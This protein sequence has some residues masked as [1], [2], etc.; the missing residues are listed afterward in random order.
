MTAVFALLA[1]AAGA[2]GPAIGVHSLSV[3]AA[4]THVLGSADGPAHGVSVDPGV[5]VRFDLA[6]DAPLSLQS[7]GL[8]LHADGSTQ[9][10]VPTINLLQAAPGTLEVWIAESATVT[11]PTLFAGANYTHVPPSPPPAPW[12]LLSDQPSHVGNLAFAAPDT[13][14]LATFSPPLSLMAGSYAVVLVAVPADVASIP[15]GAGTPADPT[16]LRIHPRYLDLATATAPTQFADAMLAVTNIGLQDRAFAAAQ[17]PAALP[18]FRLDYEPGTNVAFTESYGTGCYYRPQAFC[19]AFAAG[20][21]TD[22]SPS[23]APGILRLQPMGDRY[24]ATLHGNAAATL[25][26]APGTTTHFDALGPGTPTHVNSAAPAMALWGDWDDAASRAYPLPFGFPFPGDGGR[27]CTEIVIGSNGALWLSGELPATVR[28]LGEHDRWNE[29]PA[30]FAVAYCDLHPQNHISP[31]G[32]QGDLYID[33]DGQSRVTVSWVGLAEYPSPMGSGTD[34]SFQISLFADG[35]VEIAYANLD[36][37]TSDLL[38]G[39]TP[40]GAIAGPSLPASS[41]VDLEQALGRGAFHSGDGK[42]SAHVQ[43]TNRPAAG[44]PLVFETVDLDPSAVFNVTILATDSLPGIDL[45]AFGMPGCAALVAL[46]ELAAA[47]QL[48]TGPAIAW[49]VLPSIPA[50]FA[51]VDIYVQA[52]QLC[53]LSPTTQNA[54]GIVLSDAMRVHFD[55]N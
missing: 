55:L 51:G 10:G 16:S 28:Y 12:R 38:V 42:Q 32:G 19:Q 35:S 49:P 17:Q 23:F 7:I 14:S 33:S 25:P 54:P 50:D 41:L 37:R 45:G 15:P 2:Q 52:A 8:S 47:T 46:P 9:G 34:N 44:R 36:C 18:Q 21:G 26:F 27:P 13:L 53:A 20:Q 22:V 11:D 6:V 48:V 43:L 4:T 29:G 30:S 39:F 1:A 31:L 3:G 5:G 40:G 24:E